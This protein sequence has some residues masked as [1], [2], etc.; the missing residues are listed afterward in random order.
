MQ[1]RMQACQVCGT[2]T[3][4]AYPANDPENGPAEPHCPKC[5]RIEQAKMLL[6]AEF[7]GIKFTEA[8]IVDIDNWEGTGNRYNKAYLI[9]DHGYCL[10]VVF[11]RNEQDALDSAVDAGKLDA[12]ILSAEQ[13]AEY[14]RDGIEPCYLGNA[15]EPFDIDTIGIIELPNVPLTYTDCFNGLMTRKGANR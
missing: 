4:L 5:G 2:D 9:H 6:T 12:F 11:E 14:E 3:H 10:A 1:P 7:A 8:D 13:E 15:S